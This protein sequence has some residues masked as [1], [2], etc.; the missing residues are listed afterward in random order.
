[1]RVVLQGTRAASTPRT[2]TAPA[3]PA[4]DWRLSDAQVAVV[5]T[6][7]RNS[8]ATPQCRFYQVRAEGRRRQRRHRG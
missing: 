3:M 1:V 7:I 5:L 4:F 6:Y 8:W 2:P